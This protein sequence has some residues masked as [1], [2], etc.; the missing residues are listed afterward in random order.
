MDFFN[1]LKGTH[2]VGRLAVS[3]LL[4]VVADVALIFILSGGVSGGGTAG[5][6]V[7]GRAVRVI[8][9]SPN[10]DLIRFQDDRRRHTAGKSLRP[11]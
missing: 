9:A 4:V 7:C 1:I 8:R 3:C 10:G 11:V 2:V 6:R 5:G